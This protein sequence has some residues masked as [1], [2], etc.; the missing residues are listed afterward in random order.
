DRPAAG[1]QPVPAAVLPGT[2]KL[3]AAAPPRGGLGGGPVREADLGGGLAR[4]GG[5]GQALPWVPL[6]L[7]RGP[8][9]GPRGRRG[10]AGF[11]GRDGVGGVAQPHAGRVRPGLRDDRGRDAARVADHV[12]PLLH[13]AVPAAVALAL[14]VGRAGP[15]AGGVLGL[16]DRLVA[17]PG[18]VLARLH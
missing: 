15:A 8:G 13:A 2:A 9:A 3:A 6:P 5:G 7:F 4:R 10:G 11:R 1:L 14:L 18:P 12:G 16:R 17:V